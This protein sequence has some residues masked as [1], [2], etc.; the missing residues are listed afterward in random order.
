[1]RVAALHD[2]PIVD[3][4][5]Y[6]AAGLVLVAFCMRSMSALRWVALASNLAFI[7]YG[8]LGHIAPVLVLHIV[9][10]PVNGFRLMQHYWRERSELP[11]PERPRDAADDL[12]YSA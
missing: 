5:G 12:V 7:A 11:Q 9:L 2:I 8:F 3:G 4:I 1:M 6:A 10:L